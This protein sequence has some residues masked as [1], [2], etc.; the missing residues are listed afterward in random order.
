MQTAFLLSLL[1]L[2]LAAPARRSEPAPLLTP[3]GAQQLINDKYIVKFKTG[4]AT[5]AV[6]E[7]VRILSEDAEFKYGKVF[8]GFAGKLDAAALEQLRAH[9]D[10]SGTSLS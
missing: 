2:A 10:V 3:R 7:A 4:T 9:P 1:P 5:Q 8:R 6:D